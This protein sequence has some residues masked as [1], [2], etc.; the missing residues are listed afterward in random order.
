VRRRL[1]QLIP[2]FEAA[3]AL[4]PKRV[5][6]DTQKRPLSAVLKEMEKQTGYKVETDDGVDASG[7]SCAMKNVPFW[8]ALEMIGRETGLVLTTL[9][10]ADRMELK[11]KRRE[12][13]SAFVATEGAFR[14]EL[15]KL[16]EDRDIDFTED[17]SD[18]KPGRRAGELAVTISVRAE[19]RLLILG[20]ENPR[21][22]AALDE[23]EK[24]FRALSGSS[25]SK[26]DHAIVRDLFRVEALGSTELL[27][28]RSTDRAKMLT[29]L[30]G[31]VPV[32][33][34]V[35]R[36][37]VAVTNSIYDSKG[38]KF[39]IGGET[40]EIT[41]AEEADPDRFKLEIRVPSES[42]DLLKRWHKRIH[43]EDANGHRL[44]PSSFGS[45]SSGNEYRVDYTYHLSDDPMVGPPCKLI[46]ED[47]TM[48]EHL[49]PFEFKDVPLP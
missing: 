43:V 6:L 36:K 16:H 29:V 5:T 47:W 25:H 18:K 49:I 42:H 17:V 20:I 12:G 3:V 9:P 32:K 13:R 26:S 41:R 37:L 14:L 31:A 10:L 34:V 15:T 46:V 11:L 38:T 40:L 7:V 4:A 8:E 30:R 22:E 39:K 44:S 19:P 28:Q 45:E 48:L 24:P 27:L 21:M 33:V 23:T 1:E 35:E 2:R